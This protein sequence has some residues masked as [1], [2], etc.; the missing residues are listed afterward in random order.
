[1][2]AQIATTTTDPYAGRKATSF[3]VEQAI[4]LLLAVV[5]ALV[6]MR[7]VLRLLGANA[8]AGFA[9]LVYGVSAPVV[10]RCR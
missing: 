8:E 5:E 9:Q 4:Y 3:K 7:L 10:F 1:M 6:G 2:S